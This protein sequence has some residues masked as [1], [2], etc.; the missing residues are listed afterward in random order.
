MTAAKVALG[1]VATIDRS[2]IEPK[3]IS[4]GT[5]YVGLEHIESQTGV[6]RPVEVK[7]GEL[8]S[9][10]FQ[11]T[12]DHVLFG[13]LRPYLA[14]IACPDFNG[15][16]STDVL[17]VK[18][19]PDLDRRYLFNFLRSPA[20]VALAASR[21][22]GVNLPRLSPTEFAKIEIPLPP[23][24]E[25]R[26]I[27]AILD[28]A[29]ELRAKRRAALATLDTLTQSIFIDM[30]GSAIHHPAVHLGEAI[31]LRSG[32][33][34][35][36]KEMSPGGAYPVY[37][38]NGVAGYHS[39]F[40]YEEPRI[41]IGRVGANCGAV[42]MTAPRSWVTDNAL[43]V[44]DKPSSLD[45]GYLQMVLSKANLNQFASQSGQPSISAGR[46]G[47]VEIPIPPLHLQLAY[48]RHSSEVRDLA[49]RQQHAAA[50][51]ESLFSSLQHRAFSGSL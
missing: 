21:T 17:P 22:S 47:S 29:D 16:C 13:K 35:P 44:V 26:R 39:E 51:L 10:K 25:Q 20:T 3:R 50:A 9:S 18:P 23:L 33:F 38:G 37:G 5:A 12:P 27:A 32:Q 30:F 42:H 41:V 14:K 28:K 40:M 19:G 1:S 4:S 46:I 24:P 36:A 31:K 45:P 2:I 48:V 15:V 8:A 34:L 43:C 7:A 6:L 49:D 11:F